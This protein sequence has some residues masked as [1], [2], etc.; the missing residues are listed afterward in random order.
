MFCRLLVFIT[1]FFGA[2]LVLPLSPFEPAF[3]VGLSTT[4]EPRVTVEEL[5]VWLRELN[6]NRVQIRQVIVIDE[7]F[8]QRLTNILTT[9]QYAKL[10]EFSSNDGTIRGSI[11]DTDLG[12]SPYQQALLDRAYQEAMT[13]LIN[14]LSQE[15]Q[16]I[17]F[18][19]LEN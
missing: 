9:G 17:F 5:P 19:N 13:S 18:Y 7:L 4:L 14:I 15:Q 3:A 12:L 16:R 10:Q 11:H 1:G 8:H 6:L 2:S